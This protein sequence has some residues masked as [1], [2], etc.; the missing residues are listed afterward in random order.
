[1]KRKRRDFDSLLTLSL[2]EIIRYGSD[3]PQ[4][5]RRLRAMF[6]ELE[7]TLPTARHAGLARQRSLLDAAASAALPHPFDKVS[8]VPDRQGLG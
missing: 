2:T 8:A 4:V 3:A 1:M 6:D 7:A 5:I